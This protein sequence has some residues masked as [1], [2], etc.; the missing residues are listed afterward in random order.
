MSGK[1]APRIETLLANASID[2]LMLCVV[3]EL[4]ADPPNRSVSTCR[5]RPGES[6]SAS[7]ITPQ[8]PSKMTSDKTSAMGHETNVLQQ[9][10]TMMT[11][12]DI[13]QSTKKLLHRFH[14]YV[15]SVVTA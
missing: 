7:C 3:D 10:A 11:I 14:K 12:S 4:P 13:S 15:S 1:T 6:E 2:A 9:T 8:C 5:P